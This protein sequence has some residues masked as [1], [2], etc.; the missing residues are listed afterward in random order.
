MSVTYPVDV[1]SFRREG[2][3]GFHHF[4][5]LGFL[6]KLFPD[7]V[8]IKVESY[9]YQPAAHIPDQTACSVLTTN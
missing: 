8:E 5:S 7:A 2:T 3:H 1:N 9:I 6:A 4:Q